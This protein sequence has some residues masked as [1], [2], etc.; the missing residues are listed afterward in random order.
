MSMDHL[1]LNALE[2]ARKHD[3]SG[4][5]TFSPSNAGFGLPYDKPELVNH[6][7]ASTARQLLLHKGTLAQV[8]HLVLASFLGRSSVVFAN[9]VFVLLR[10][11]DRQ[12]NPH[13]RAL[14]HASSN[15]IQSGWPGEN[16]RMTPVTVEDTVVLAQT[17][18]GDFIYLDGLDAGV[19]P[20]IIQS[21]SWEPNIET[22]FLSELRPGMTVVD[23][24]ANCGYFTLSA[25]REVGSAG[26]VISMEPNPKLARLLV[27]SV[28]AN[29]FDD[30]CRVIN[31]AATAENGTVELTIPS[32]GSSYGTLFGSQR[33]GQRLQVSGHT[34]DSITDQSVDVLKI[35]AE[36]SEWLVW[37]GST[38]I[39][40]RSQNIKIFMEF[41]P[42]MINH[43]IAPS[44]FLSKIRNFGFDIGL[45]QDKSVDFT[46]SDE[47]LLEKSWSELFIGRKN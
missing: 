27:Q 15:L 11:D 14:D 36:G 23:V 43:T 47:D 35:D 6:I 20:K 31:A 13:I 9:E 5:F 19:T 22:L 41:M 1:W 16:L 24:G 4:A 12:R 37:S 45:I 8:P 40:N 26:T 17:W 29:N 42:D 30:R 32:E 44:D 2:H 18:R 21:G 28:Y 46:L 33:A 3:S 10:K 7:Q 34:L 38:Q 25:A 39:L